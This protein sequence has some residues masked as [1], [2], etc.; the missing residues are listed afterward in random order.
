MP[1]LALHPRQRDDKDRTAP[2]MQGPIRV[3][4]RKPTRPRGARNLT[5]S[6]ATWQ[7]F[8]ALAAVVVAS[9]SLVIVAITN[10][11][12]DLSVSR[13]RS[14]GVRILTFLRDLRFSSCARRV[15]AKAFVRRVPA[16]R[17]LAIRWQKHSTVLSA[18]AVHCGTH[19]PPTTVSSPASGSCAPSVW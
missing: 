16:S 2:Y 5:P 10:E 14:R 13:S 1:P 6:A 7:D 19:G 8:S 18:Q 3:A 17:V 9:Q 4:W 12:L 15:V 11:S